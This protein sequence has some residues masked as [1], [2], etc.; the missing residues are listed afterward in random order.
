MVE[1]EIKMVEIFDRELP[2]DCKKA[3]TALMKLKVYFVMNDDTIDN[4]ADVWFR[5]Q[6]ECDM[7]VDMQ[8][9]YELTYQSYIVAKN[10][11]ENWRHLYI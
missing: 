2:N 7:Y 4:F 10:W 5:V 3:I 9:S 1:K 6:H 11:V 8:D